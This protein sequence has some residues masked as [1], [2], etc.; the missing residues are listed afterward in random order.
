MKLGC[1]SAT[2]PPV[3]R[4]ID[5]V[6][7]AERLGFDSVWTAEAYGSDCFSRCAGSARALADQLGTA[8]MQLSRAR[9][10]VRR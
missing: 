8:V 3:R 2:G 7:E 5:L 6:L 9:R 4:S 10:R 1:N